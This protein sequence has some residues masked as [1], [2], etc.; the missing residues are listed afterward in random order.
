MPVTRP[1][2]RRNQTGFVPGDLDR[3]GLPAAPALNLA[4]SK[5]M[6]DPSTGNVFH[7]ASPTHIVT[8]PA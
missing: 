8:R 2:N 5:G 4:P 7:V 1:L 3:S 6:R